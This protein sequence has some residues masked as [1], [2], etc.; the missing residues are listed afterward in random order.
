M[1]AD[2]GKQCGADF[3]AV[4][5]AA[6][7]SSR[8]KEFKPLLPIG[9]VTALELLI[10]SVKA[11]G[12]DRIAVVTG[13]CREK[14]RNVFHK[15]GAV[16]LYNEAFAD[17][18]FSS[19]QAGIKGAESAFQG[20]AGYFLMPVDC[21]LI[22]SSVISAMI[23]LINDDKTEA[24]RGRGVRGAQEKA[25]GAAN[26][27]RDFY[28]PVFEGKKGHPLFIPAAYGG[29]ICAY[30]GTGGLK[31]ITDKYWDRM[32]RVPV[33][34]EGCVLD[35]DT[36]EGYREI[37]DFRNAGCVRPPLEKL[38]AGRRIF[39]VRHGQTRQHDEKMLIGQYDVPLNDE[40]R[41]RI[42]DTARKIAALKP[43]IDIIYSSDLD[44][45]AESA[46]ILEEIIGPAKIRHVKE[47]REINLGG[48]D[49]MPVSYIRENYPDEYRRRGEDIFTFKTGN[50]SE[51]FYDIQYRAVKALRR[52]L[53]EDD[54]RDI[55]IVT[56]SGIA[57]AIEN[58]LKGLRVDDDWDSIPKG[59]FRL[60]Q[61]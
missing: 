36:P 20:A 61:R 27:L 22:D 39:L 40:G 54:S 10:S 52:I 12:I 26:D 35:M 11:A 4:I 42:R 44:R 1:T 33:D 47:F 41:S 13:F 58:N 6:G 50:K 37:L 5:L 14:L 60:I 45:A 28:V 29:E 34:S 24:S 38:A 16:E 2:Y 15:T 59:G 19:I 53:Q 51:N 9:E 31:A 49:G 56:H 32:V 8:M 55:V 3:A 7:Y 30:D 18:M 43:E 46:S 57:R 23:S 17:G 21:P 25:E 48:W